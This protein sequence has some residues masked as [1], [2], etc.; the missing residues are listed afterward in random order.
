[1]NLATMLSNLS[2]VEYFYINSYFLKFLIAKKIPKLLP[3]AISSLKHLWFLGIQLGDLDQLHAVLC[4]LQNSP[5]LEKLFVRH[6]DMEPRV[7]VG[8]ASDHLESPNYLDSTLDQLKIVEMTCLKGS[9]P[10]LLF[11]KLLLAHS[12]SLQKF[13][14]KPSRASNVKKRYDIVKE[15]MQF[16]RASAKAKMFCLDS[17]TIIM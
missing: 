15:V 10:E 13:T 6:L 2:K 3:R 17:G 7:D 8:P 14:I 9:K 5:N 1:M 4:F 11:I 12:P 16:P